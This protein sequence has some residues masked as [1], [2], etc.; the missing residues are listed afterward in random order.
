MKDIDIHEQAQII[1]DNKNLYTEE[2]YYA[3]LDEWKKDF[4]QYLINLIKY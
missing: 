2:E 1:I 4:K 3:L